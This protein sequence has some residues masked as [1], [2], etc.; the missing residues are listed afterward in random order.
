MSTSREILHSFVKV[1]KDILVVN[2]KP[3]QIKVDRTLVDL[4]ELIELVS[5]LVKIMDTSAPSTNAVV[6]REKDSGVSQYSLI[7]PPEKADKGKGIAQTSDDDTLKQIMPFIDEGGSA[8]SLTNLQHF[9]AARE[10]PMT[11]EEAK[12]HMQKAKRLA[13]LKADREKSKKKLRTLTSAQQM[14]QEE[15]LAEIEAKRVQHMNKIRDEYN[16]CIHFKDDPLP[17]LK[18]NYRVSKALKIAT[19]RITRNNQPVKL[20]I[21]NNFILKML[22][23]TKWLELHNLASKRQNV[24]N[25]QLLKNL[26]AKFKWVATIADKLGLLSPP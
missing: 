19:R 2:V 26:K 5:Q 21:Y 25:D 4:H 16:H 24:T 13:D 14:A 22:G 8:P 3:L 7:P 23:F 10:L 20:K 12:L 9:K 18:F 11:L 1:P 15:E 6:K 17:I